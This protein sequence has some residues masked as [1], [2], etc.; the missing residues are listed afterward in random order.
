MKMIFSILI[1]TLSMSIGCSTLKK[2]GCRIT[3]I[4][5]TD[6]EEKSTK[7]LSEFKKYCIELQ[8]KKKK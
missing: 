1:L 8:D 3:S 5:Q 4:V 6:V 7:D 2:V